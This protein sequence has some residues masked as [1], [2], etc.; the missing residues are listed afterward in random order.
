MLLNN[1]L[2]SIKG[3]TAKAWLIWTG[4]MNDNV[5]VAPRTGHGGPAHATLCPWP[6]YGRYKGTGDPKD[7]ANFECRS[8]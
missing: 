8:D 2:I 3:Y 4:V 1:L 7:A 5:R 6:Q